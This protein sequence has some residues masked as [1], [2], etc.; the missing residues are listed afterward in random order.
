MLARSAETFSAVKNC[1]VQI[2][3]GMIRIK[4]RIVAIWDQA[5]G[6]AGHSHSFV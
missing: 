6:E 1:S 3:N 4:M 2:R 5:F